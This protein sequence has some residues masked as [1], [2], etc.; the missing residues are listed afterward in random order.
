MSNITILQCDLARSWDAQHLLA[1]HLEE[2]QVN[3]CLISEPRNVPDSPRWFSSD[4]GL[5]A[6]HWGCSMNSEK[7]KLVA[8]KRFSCGKICGDTPRV[9]LYISERRSS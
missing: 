2:L 8:K 9:V 1:K 7:C 3:I 6:I 5:A 4:N